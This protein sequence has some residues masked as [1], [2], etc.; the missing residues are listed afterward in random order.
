VHRHQLIVIEF[1]LAEDWLL[2][3]AC[4]DGES[5]SPMRSGCSGAEAQSARAKG[6]LQLDTIVSPD[7]LL[8]WHGRL[9]A[10][11]WIL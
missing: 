8:R 2:K 5:G 6:L 1:L 10:D 3:R 7:T 9:V 4:A 11:K